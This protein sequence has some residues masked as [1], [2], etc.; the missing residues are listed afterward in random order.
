[1]F[2]RFAEPGSIRRPLLDFQVLPDQ[3]SRA[4]TYNS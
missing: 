2:E 3:V 1:M 4:I